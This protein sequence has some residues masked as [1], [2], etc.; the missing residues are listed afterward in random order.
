VLILKQA[1]DLGLCLMKVNVAERN[2]ME[3]RVP[4][5]LERIGNR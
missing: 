3:T 1:L 4:E 2:R 5:P